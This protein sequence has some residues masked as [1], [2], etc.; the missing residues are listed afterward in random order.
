MRLGF[1]LAAALAAVAAAGASAAPAPTYTVAF[2]GS[3]TE[4]Q[5][6]EKRNIQDSGACDSAE[7]VDVTATMVWSTS[8]PG[9][10]PASRSALATPTRI[11]GSHVDGTHV[12]DACGL[13]LDQAPEGWA[14]QSSCSD[15]LV[16]SG[17]PQLTAVVGKKAVTI[18]LAAPSFAVPVS[19]SCALNVRNDQLAAHVI[20]ALKKLQSLK[21]HASLSFPVGTAVPGPGDS[22][23]PSLDCSVPTKPYEGYRTADHCQDQLSWSG[24]LTITRAS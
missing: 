1:C 13:P 6:D 19:A 23:A 9:F 24:T 14:A 12:K 18:A 10:R 3:G 2:Q 7:H 20:V 15:A 5:I 21:R 16:P 4:H 22:Y 8:W 11:D 17:S